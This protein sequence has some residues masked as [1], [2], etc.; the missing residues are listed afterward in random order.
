MGRINKKT[1]KVGCKFF[2]YFQK[3]RKKKANI[4]TNGIKDKYNNLQEARCN[5]GR[6]KRNDHK[7]KKERSQVYYLS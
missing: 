2:A 5:T 1:F 6:V 7:K 4:I 3:N